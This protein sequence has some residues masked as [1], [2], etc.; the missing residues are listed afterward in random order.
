M[1]EVP[2]ARLGDNLVLGEHTHAVDLRVRVR[3][4]GLT[5]ANDLILTK[6]FKDKAAQTR[7]GSAAHIHTVHTARALW[8]QPSSATAP[9][10]PCH[11][12]HRLYTTVYNAMHAVTHH[13]GSDGRERLLQLSCLLMAHCSLNRRWWLEVLASFYWL[14]G[15]V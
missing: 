8:W 7:S 14:A 2:E 13:H 3:L 10:A 12:A 9:G 5:T 15:R 1:Q 6:L 11:A 4:C